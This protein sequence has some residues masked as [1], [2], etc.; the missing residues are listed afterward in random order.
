M[1]ESEITS[2]IRPFSDIQL[3]LNEAAGLAVMVEIRMRLIGELSK[4]VRNALKEVVEKYRQETHKCK[5]SPKDY[6]YWECDLWFLYNGP[7]KMDR[8][9][10]Y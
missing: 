2:M 7:Q 9:T 8:P 1:T 10:S 6:N 3:K 5:K 4:E